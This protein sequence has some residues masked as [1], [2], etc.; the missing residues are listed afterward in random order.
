MFDRQNLIRDSH[1]D[2]DT[3]PVISHFYVSFAGDDDACPT[4]KRNTVHWE[5]Q[6]GATPNTVK[7]RPWYSILYGYTRPALESQ[8]SGGKK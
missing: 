5:T 6:G 7:K 3:R 1:G 4:K 8:F 2:D